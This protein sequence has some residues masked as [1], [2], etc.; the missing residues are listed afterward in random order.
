MRVRP[1]RDGEESVLRSVFESA[2]RGSAARYYAPEQI[3]AWASRRAD[4]LDWRKRIQEIQPFVVEVDDGIVGYADVQS[5]G[6]IDHFF[7]RASH[8]RQGVGS[9]LLRHLE[10]TAR[11]RGIVELYADVSLAAEAF[12]ARHG[13]VVEA[14][15]EVIVAGVMLRNARMRKIL[16]GSAEREVAP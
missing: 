16:D 8:S 4:P 11:A 6:Y 1:Y 3:D 15:Q 12:F 5:S 2:V 7:V 9:T 14:R 13:F 10:A